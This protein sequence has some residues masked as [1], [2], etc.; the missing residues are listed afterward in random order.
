[1]KNGDA[2]MVTKTTDF[3]KNA[4]LIKAAQD[5]PE[6]GTNWYR[7]KG[8]R[9]EALYLGVG[10]R[11]AT[12]YLKRRINGKPKD[13][14]IGTFPELSAPQAYTKA[15]T[16]GDHAE[17]NADIGTV[18]AGWEFHCETSQSMDSMSDAHRR[19]M[20]AK[21]ERYAGNVLAMHPADVTSAHVQRIINDLATDGKGATARHVRA[22]LRSAF[23]YTEVANPV[24]NK[25]VRAPKAE[26]RPTLWSDACGAHP[27]LDPDDWSQIWEAIMLKRDKNVLIGT[28]WVVMLFTGI[29][30][31]NVMSL[32]WDQV[33]LQKGT[34]SFEKLKSGVDRELPVCDTVLNALKAIR[35]GGSDF[36]FPA[37]SKSG[38][39]DYPPDLFLVIEGNR[40]PIARNHDSRS[41]F[42]QAAAEAFLPE[43]VAH[44]LR[45]DKLGG[46]GSDMLMKY[47]KRMGNR[48]AVEVIEGVIHERIKVTPSFELDDL[49]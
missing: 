39:I 32:T 25:K 2:D 7:H 9:F 4:L 20:T 14:R 26:E 31:G 34:L 15:G 46:Q 24:A 38:H 36:V 33:N 28:A 27:H 47:L 10:K 21:L 8:D 37:S 45:G 29:R 13:I 42:M 35:A 3:T 19:D 17:R 1:M 43:Y 5:K 16:K 12:W 18:R 23:N 30:A 41:H 40:I 48:R 22:A 49:N 6:K 11:R 44:H